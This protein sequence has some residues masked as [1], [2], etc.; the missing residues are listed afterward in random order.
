MTITAAD[1]VR[2]FLRLEALRPKYQKRKEELL[3]WCELPDNELM[4]KARQFAEERDDVNP[5]L[6]YTVGTPKDNRY[7]RVASWKRERIKCKDIFTSGISSAMLPDIEV[8]KGNIWD[9]ALLDFRTFQVK[10]FLISAIR[11]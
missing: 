9:F 3:S 6:V 2:H 4:L 7:T 8:A 5:T 1:V 10:A 11:N